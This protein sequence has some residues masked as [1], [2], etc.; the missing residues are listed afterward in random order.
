MTETAI[1]MGIKIGP[2]VVMKDWYR[3]DKF[4]LEGNGR[5]II[6]ENIITQSAGDDRWDCMAKH[7]V[8]D[9]Q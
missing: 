5:I 9:L 6:R 4:G 7:F 3:F 2:S 1:E 8:E